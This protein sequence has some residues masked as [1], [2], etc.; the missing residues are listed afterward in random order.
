[1]KI[2]SDSSEGLGFILITDRKLCETNLTDIIKQAIEGGIGTVQ[3]REK[4]L[5]TVALYRLAKE[6]REITDKR[7]VKLIIND[8]VDIAIAVGADGVHLG[9]QSM[10][11]GIVRSMV[12]QDKL[13]GFSAHSLAEAERA[14]N[15]GVDYITI[16]PVFDTANKDYYLTPLGVDEIGKIMEQINIPVIALGGI[17]ENNVN[18][19]LDSGV[20]GIAVISAILQSDSPVQSATRI[21]RKIIEFKLK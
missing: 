19:V 16:S 15:S 10:E 7:N 21:Y 3:L 6:I 2:M 4:G 8:R 17:N 5:S 13:I 12:G 1:M 9:W 20:D 14:E 11:A 18:I